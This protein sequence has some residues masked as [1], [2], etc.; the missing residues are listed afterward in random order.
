MVQPLTGL[1]GWTNPNPEASAEQLHG[2]AADPRHGTAGEQAAPYPWEVF[3]DEP[4]GPYGLDNEL[5]GMD[6]CSY[7]T[8]AGYLGQDPRGDEQPLTNAAPWPKGVPQSVDPDAV[9]AR[10]IES[11]DI[12]SSAMGA[13]RRSNTSPNGYL[14]NDTW[15][16]MEAVDP[17]M[18]KPPMVPIP[19]QVM[20]GSGGWGSR[21]RVQSRAGQNE[22]GF[23]SAHMHRRY[24]TG[25][26]PGNYMW[27]EPGQRPMVKSIPGTANVP[28]GQDSPFAGQVPGDAFTSHGSALANLPTQYVAPPDPA[29]APAYSQDQ[30]PEVN[31]W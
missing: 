26:I 27:M 18:T 1:Q 29:L 12:H 3:P 22:Y 8:P 10:R 24:A 17:G 19:N 21:D 15:D 2:N 13:S 25:S 5:L 31:L 4:H 28:V 9:A 6:I 14:Q 20:T 23:D 16:T 7:E 30:A 11:M